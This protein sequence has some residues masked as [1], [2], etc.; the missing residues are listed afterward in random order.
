M[1][2]RPRARRR[3]D[4]APHPRRARVRGARRGDGRRARA[5]R[6]APTRSRRASAPRRPVAPFVGR[7][8]ETRPPASPC[9]TSARTERD[10]GARDGARL[11][12]RR[13]DAPLARAR[14]STLERRRARARVRD[15]L[16][17]RRVAHVRAG[18]RPARAR[19]PGW[20]SPRP[21]TAS[22]PRERIGAL[23]RDDADRARV[24]DVLAGVLGAAPARSVEETF[25]A[26]RRIVE[27][28]AADRPLVVVIDDI[29]W[30]EPMLLDL[31]EHL[32]EWVHGRRGA[33]RRPRPSRAARGAAGARRA[34]SPGRRRRRA[35]R[36]RR[37]GDRGARRRA[38]RQRAAAPGSSTGCPTSTDGNPLF[39]RE[40]VRMLV[41]DRSSA[42]ATTARGSSRSTP[43]RSRCRRR[44][45]RCS[46]RA[47]SAC[48]P[49]S[50]AARARVGGRR[51]VQPRRAARARRRRPRASRRCSNG[52]GARSWSSRPAPTGATSR[53]TASTT[54]S[55][56]TPR[57]G[58]C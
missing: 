51:R 48:P 41:D 1:P 24:V 43:R 21:T 34:G 58:G 56:A 55:S 57:T 28:L 30:A 38:A 6:S 52:C 7:D 26:V 36:P 45:S 32:A 3:R 11:A 29:Q 5:A 50:A 15:P 33:A 40:L 23:V 37:V 54:C 22:T 35:R 8:A 31:I 44:S 25:W 53:S 16:R 9:S 2:A 4:V 14:G 39:V 42:V 10:R 46:P 19:P 49:T 47:S 27:S 18:R 17:P 13:Q 20:R 12:R